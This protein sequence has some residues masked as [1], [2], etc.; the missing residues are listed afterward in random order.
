M[1]LAAG[2]DGL[3]FY[4]RLLRDAPPLLNPGGRLIMELGFGQADVV[5]QWA[6]QSGAFDVVECR[7]DAAGVVRVLSARRAAQRES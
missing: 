1:A 4:R 2:P 7:K 5:T 6:W 3:T